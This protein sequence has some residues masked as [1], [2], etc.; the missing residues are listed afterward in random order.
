MIDPC[1]KTDV[2]RRFSC[3]LPVKG[4]QATTMAFPDVT[5]V[6]NNALDVVLFCT[7]RLV[8]IVY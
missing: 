2:G 7:A 8:T 5:S 3:A 1:R 4:R 6:S